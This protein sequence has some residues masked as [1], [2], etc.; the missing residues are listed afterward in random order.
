MSFR[1]RQPDYITAWAQIKVFHPESHA[2]IYP[3]NDFFNK[4]YILDEPHFKQMMLFLMDKNKP[5]GMP[6]YKF[7]SQTPNQT[8]TPVDYITDLLNKKVDLWEIPVY[9]VSIFHNSL[10]SN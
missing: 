7:L 9:I 1:R 10:N 6:G 4:V 2:V 3:Y 8:Y 5:I